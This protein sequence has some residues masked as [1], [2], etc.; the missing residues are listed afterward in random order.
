MDTKGIDGYWIESWYFFGTDGHL[1]VLLPK[2][3]LAESI[4]FNTPVQHELEKSALDDIIKQIS[5]NSC[6]DT[7]KNERRREWRQIVQI[8]EKGY[9]KIETDST[10][11]WSRQCVTVLV[12]S[13]VCQQK[14][15]GCDGIGGACGRP[16]RTFGLDKADRGMKVIW[17]V[18]HPPMLIRGWWMTRA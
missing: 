17:C 12:L 1:W 7:V 2:E 18:F 13:P 11:I 5:T 3:R 14:I 6:L 10:E 9:T 8:R 4:I 15:G 16:C